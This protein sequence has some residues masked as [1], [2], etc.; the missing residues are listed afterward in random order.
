MSVEAVDVEVLQC[1]LAGANAPISRFLATARVLSSKPRFAQGGSL[2]RPPH[3][4]NRST[5]Y[6]KRP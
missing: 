6:G 2:S 3:D 4:E 1:R 5:C